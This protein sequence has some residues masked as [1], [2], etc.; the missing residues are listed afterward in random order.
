M[1][2][3]TPSADPTTLTVTQDAAVNWLIRSV[4]PD[5]LD[6]IEFEEDA[7]WFE[8]LPPYAGFTSSGRLRGWSGA[9]KRL[10]RAQDTLDEDYKKLLSIHN[11]PISTPP[12]PAEENIRALC[13][14]ARHTLYPSRLGFHAYRIVGTVL[15]LTDRA[16]EAM[17]TDPAARGD[18]CRARDE[19]WR[20]LLDL[21][22]AN[23][24][25]PSD[26]VAITTPG[27]VTPDQFATS[28]AA[29]QDAGDVLTDAS[30]A[31]D[32]ARDL[33]APHTCTGQVL[34]SDD[35]GS[36]GDIAEPCGRPRSHSGPCAE[37]PT[38]DDLATPGPY[39]DLHAA[40]TT[41]EERMLAANR[42]FVDADEALQALQCGERAA[43]DEW[44]CT[45]RRGHPGTHHEPD[46][47]RLIL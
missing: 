34:I 7:A 26:R 41:T 47:L 24:A 10:Q 13:T 25:A 32:G 27:A 11:G 22:L 18:L 21:L 46:E 30:A 2:T 20:E 3:T 19:V 28:L 33:I 38:D 42:R 8:A 4:I 5:L 12:M 43:P 39:R 36:H 23:G 44:G 37:K 31:F 9:I 1:T 17:E 35:E 16:I 14:L 6:G 29:Q 40:L 45:L 15:T